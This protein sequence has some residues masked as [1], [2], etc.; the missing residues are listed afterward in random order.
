MKLSAKNTLLGAAMSILTCGFLFSCKEGN[1]NNQ[2]PKVATTVAEGEKA[3]SSQ[4]ALIAYVDLDT[5]EVKYEFWQKKKS[6]FET[7]QK[8]M[9]AE[10][11]KMGRNFQNQMEE[12][13][14]KAQ[15][16]SYTQSEGEAAQKKLADLQQSLERKH[17]NMTNQLLK[18]QQDFNKELQKR[19]DDYLA[20][21][22][23]DKKYAYILSYSKGSGSI[24]YADPNMN[25][26]N[27]VI[28]GLNAANT[29]AKK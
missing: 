19:L 3:T 26:T 9:E 4:N 25:I 23:K 18:D 20:E 17:E 15:A 22:N 10:L 1:K 5:L 28:E 16:G 21:F 27:E 14:R 29:S 24:L 12:F 7:R 13:Q 8:N 6:E 2:T 11:D